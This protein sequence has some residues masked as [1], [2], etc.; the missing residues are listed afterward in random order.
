MAEKIRLLFVAAQPGNNASLRLDRE[1]RAITQA[2]SREAGRDAVDLRF[3]WATGISDLQPALR[4]HRPHIVHFAGHGGREAGIYLESSTGDWQPV[5][6]AALGNLFA[7]LNGCVRLVVLNA[8]ETHALTDAFADVVDYM[9]GMSHV[10]HDDA[11]LAFSEA[12]YGALAGGSSVDQ[13]FAMGVNRLELEAHEDADV[14]M[15]RVR[16]GVDRTGSIFPRAPARTEQAP[17]RRDGPGPHVTVRDQAHVGAMNIVDAE[18]SVIHTT[19]TQ[20]GR[21][22]ASDSDG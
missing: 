13:A 5:H 17:R 22:P 21:P 10:V 2:I 11:S 4:Q 7:A 12:F 3:E 8:C 14:P 16:R 19:I 18:R 1:A 15:L 9:V 20:G 6:K